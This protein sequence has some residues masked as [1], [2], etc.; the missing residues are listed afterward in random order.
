MTNQIVHVVDDEPGMR[1]SLELLLK[2]E[3]Y[4]VRTYPSAEAFSEAYCEEGP[5]CL[6]LD[7]CLEG[8]ASGLDLQAELSEGRI[9]I[10]IIMMSAQAIAP[11]IVQAMQ[12]GAVTFLQ[13]PFSDEAL[14]SQI[15]DAISWD[16]EGTDA[17][18]QI[19]Q[20]MQTL[21]PRECEVMERLLRGDNTKSIAFELKVS[22]QTIDK[23]RHK[24]FE[25]MR[26]A[27][28]V[29]LIRLVQRS[30]AASWNKPFDAI[31]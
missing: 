24:I 19:R 18:F 7:V 23:H 10:P 2:A 3:R 4:E 20:R 14:I 1:R 15:H 25:K 22:L 16:S 8:G 27:S 6:L 5:A 13:K 26:V 30:H 9:F 21:S 11:N 12:G 17:P 31:S 28:T 29:D